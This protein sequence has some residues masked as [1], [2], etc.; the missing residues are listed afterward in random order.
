[1]G[2][3]ERRSHGRVAADRL[4]ENAPAELGRWPK[5]ASA[6]V[7]SARHDPWQAWRE[8]AYRFYAGGWLLALLGTRIQNTVLAWEIYAQT[9]EAIALGVAGLVM[10]LPAMLFA[11]PAGFLGDR[12]NRV[13]L[14]MFSLGGMTVTSI[15]LALASAWAMPITVIYVLLFLDG[16]AIMLGRPARVALVPMLVPA[17]VLPNAITWTTGMMH[18]TSVV[19][20]ALGGLV[21]NLHMQAGYWLAAGSS[22]L[23]ALLLS[24]LRIQASRPSI[25]QSLSLH[26]LLLGI[27]F[28]FGTRIILGMITLDL[29]AVLFGGAVYLLPIFAQEILQVGAQGFGWLRSAPAVGAVAM[30]VLLLVMP[31]M[32]RAGAALLIN[33][34]A[35]GL[36][37]IIFGLSQSYGLSFAMLALTGAFDNVSM[38]VRG[39]LQQLLTPDE[40]R[41]RVSSV[42]SVFVSASNELGGFESGLVAQ[43]FGP[44]VSVVSGGIASMAV[45]GLVA[46]MAPAL[47][48]IRRLEDVQPA[49]L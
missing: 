46:S 42:S 25:P 48:K 16:T 43:Y 27:R 28:V 29:F 47:R 33:V 3:S 35:F 24:F 49:H 44:V 41:G 1:M 15:G 40:M 13:R 4:T 34:A 5:T 2:A 36:A 9:Q 17:R 45:V 19:G 18:L 22:A 23:F 21:I 7:P 37:T 26:N 32:Q 30:S 38:V 14:V 12:F 11:L 20:P 10:A 8:P 6:P 31:P 39:T